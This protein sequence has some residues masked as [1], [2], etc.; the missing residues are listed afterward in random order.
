MHAHAVQVLAIHVIDFNNN[1]VMH[2]Y[3]VRYILR[4]RSVQ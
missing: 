1:V 3:L 2:S 4:G